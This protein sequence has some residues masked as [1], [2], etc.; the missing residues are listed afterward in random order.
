MK[1]SNIPSATALFRCRS[2]YILHSCDRYRCQALPRSETTE[3]KAGSFTDGFTVL[4]FWTI[5]EVR[6]AIP[7]AY[8]N[9]LRATFQPAWRARAGPPAFRNSTPARS[10]VPLGDKIDILAPHFSSTRAASSVQQIVVSSRVVKRIYPRCPSIPR[11]EV[12]RSPYGISSSMKRS[13]S[14]PGKQ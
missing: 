1:L 13:I 12:V 7:E 9:R 14:L 8:S 11:S 3:K 2:F 10:C 6:L 4:A 5:R